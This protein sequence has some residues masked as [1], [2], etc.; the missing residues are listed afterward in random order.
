MIINVMFAT[1][2]K[3]LWLNAATVI[4]I[5][6]FYVLIQMDIHFKLNKLNKKNIFILKAKSYVINTKM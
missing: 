5:Y 3:D 4:I 6:T 1:Q 2:I